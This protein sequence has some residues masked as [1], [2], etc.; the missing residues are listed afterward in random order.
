VFAFTD[1]AGSLVLADG[2]GRTRAVLG[3]AAD[4]SPTILFADRGG[5]TRAGLGVDQRG[6]GT[7]TLVDRSGRDLA[8]P[9]P[10]ADEQA[11]TSQAPAP[12]SRR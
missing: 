11:D 12:S 5:T 7:L 1:Q 2:A 6:A 8:Q 9:E 3:I 4:G 10:P